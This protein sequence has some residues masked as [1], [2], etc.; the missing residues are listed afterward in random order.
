MDSETIREQRS[1]LL[2]RPVGLEYETHPIAEGFPRMFDYGF[3]ALREDI[4]ENGLIYPITLL[5]GMIL[6]GRNRYRACK[7]AGVP[8]RAVTFQGENPWRFLWSVNGH[9]HHF[10]NEVQQYLVF[11][12]IDE[13]AK[14]FER[15]RSEVHDKANQARSEK[16]KEQHQISNPRRGES[17]GS[18]TN[19]ADTKRDHKAEEA[20]RNAAMAAWWR[21]ET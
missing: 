11:Q 12:R 15:I 13:G 17:S 6:D 16:A 1:A 19:C 5:D 9:R 14:E 8:I 18:R 21:T 20:N 4:R 2:I 3:T 10:R 7:E